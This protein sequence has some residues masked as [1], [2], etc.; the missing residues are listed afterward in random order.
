[1]TAITS[2]SKDHMA[3]LG[4]TLESIAYQKAGIVKRGVPVVLGPMDEA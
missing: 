2:I 1:M 3:Q 4:N